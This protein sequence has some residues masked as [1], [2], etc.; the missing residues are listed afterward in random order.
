[1]KHTTL[2]VIGACAAK[3]KECTKQFATKKNVKCA[4]VCTRLATLL[5]T[6]K[7]SVNV[8]AA[9]CKMR[10][11]RFKGDWEDDDDNPQLEKGMV[12]A[13]KIMAKRE[14]RQSKVL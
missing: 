3:A 1:M 4:H 10:R 5:A 11:T 13:A 14:L 9:I 12:V 8:V 7:Q 2:I 6:L